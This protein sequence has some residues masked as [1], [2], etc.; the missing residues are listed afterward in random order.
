MSTQYCVITYMEKESER[1]WIY[2]YV[3]VQLIHFAVTLKLTQH[4]KYTQIK[5]KQQK[6]GRVG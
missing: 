2:A 6:K 3:H 4:C 5:L 1:E